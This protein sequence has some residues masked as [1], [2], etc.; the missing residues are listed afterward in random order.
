MFDQTF[1][2]THAQTRKPFT[3]AVSLGIQTLFVG[4]LLLVPILHPEIL[5]P[6]INV[7]LYVHLRAAPEPPKVA[8]TPTAAAG[9]AHSP[10]PR[11]FVAPT[12]IPTGVRH[13]E[14]AGIGAPDVAIAG[15]AIGV[16]SGGPSLSDL[17][18]G[19][20]IPPPPVV[21]QP[22]PVVKAP[23]APA[24]PVSV[25]SGVQSA[26]LIFG[27]KPLYPALGKATRVQGTVKIQAV[28]AAD[29]SIG[30][31]KVMSGPPLLIS[32]AMEAVSRWRYQPTLLSGKAVEVI[33]EID[34]VFTLSQ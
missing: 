33:T 26:K 27:P 18:P 32:A 5:Q 29:G 6:K 25:S 23:A 14:D 31:L 21:K 1:V 9:T 4:T 19:V 20:N 2:N 11:A 8:T 16:G 15:P 12:T 3:I 28:I 34:V 30:N 22:P 7:P 13:I 10:V 24:G 17:I